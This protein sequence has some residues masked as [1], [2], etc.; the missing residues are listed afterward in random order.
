[1]ANTKVATRGRSLARNA[2]TF[3]RDLG[4][5]PRYECGHYCES[6]DLYEAESIEITLADPYFK[7][8]TTALQYAASKGGNLKSISILRGESWSLFTFNQDYSGI[9]V[10]MCDGLV[11]VDLLQM[12]PK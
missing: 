12:P 1:M 7:V 4:L 5:R 2:L 9:L 10:W 8:W 3:V 6:H 11:G